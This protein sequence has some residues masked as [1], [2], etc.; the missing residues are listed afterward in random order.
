MAWE[1]PVFAWL[2]AC[3][4][5]TIPL[6]E[7]CL[8]PGAVCRWLGIPGR[9]AIGVEGVE[10]TEAFTCQ[11]RDVLFSGGSAVFIDACNHRV[12]EVRDGVVNTIAGTGSSGDPDD[13][14]A[15]RAGCPATETPLAEPEDVVVGPGGDLTIAVA[16]F[17]ETAVLDRAEGELAWSGGVAPWSVAYDGDTLYVLGQDAALYRVSVEPLLYAG[18]PGVPGTSGDGGPAR[19]ALLPSYGRIVLDGRLLYVVDAYGAVVR[20]IDLDT[21]LI[22]R[23]AGVP[24]VTGSTDGDDALTALFELP[25]DVAVGLE[26]ELYVADAYNGCVREVRD[27]VISTFVGQCGPTQGIVWSADGTDRRDAQLTSPFGLAVDG[28]GV[29]FVT[30]VSTNV[31]WRVQP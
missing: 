4:E 28:D 15:C 5:A 20:A 9:V 2:I 21:G 27:G 11:P 23:V 25:M 29:V 16:G 19:D 1:V 24:G 10:R 22:D 30:D 31:I 12:R 8:A 17:E 13:R 6:D 7:T 18:T 26:G 14:P 3:S